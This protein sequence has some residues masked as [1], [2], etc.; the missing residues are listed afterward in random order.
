MLTDDFNDSFND[1]ISNSAL[2][3]GSQQLVSAD[4]LMSMSS[5]STLNKQQPTAPLPTVSLTSPHHPKGGLVGISIW[6]RYPRW[7]C[8]CVCLLV[9]LYVWLAGLLSVASLVCCFCGAFLCAR[10]GECVFTSSVRVCM[11]VSVPVPVRVCICVVCVYCI[12]LQWQWQ[13]II[14]L[15]PVYVQ[16]MSNLRPEKWSRLWKVDCKVCVCV[17]VRNQA[18]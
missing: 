6:G 9:G 13:T 17:P 11:P 10:A 7:I 5:T 2:N 8:L 14:Q 3:S 16:P 18:D 12:F 15:R 1:I 4:D